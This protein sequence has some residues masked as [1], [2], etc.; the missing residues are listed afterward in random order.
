M[1]TELRSPFSVMAPKGKGRAIAFIDHQTGNPV[2]ILVE[3]LDGGELAE[4]ALSELKSTS[5]CVIGQQEQ[6]TG[7]RT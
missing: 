2:K 3:Y 4:V 7:A 1:I 5:V 6:P